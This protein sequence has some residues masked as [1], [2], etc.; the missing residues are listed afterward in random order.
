MI[1]SWFKSNSEMAILL[2]IIVL[3]GWVRRPTKWRKKRSRWLNAKIWS[4]WRLTHWIKN[5]IH[6]RKRSF[7]LSHFLNLLITKLF[8]KAQ[9]LKLKH[10][11]SKERVE[12]Q[13][14]LRRSNNNRRKISTQISE[15][16]TLKREHI[17]SL[18]MQLSQ[19]PKADSITWPRLLKF[20]ILAKT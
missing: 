9:S 6:L 10:L 4:M 3:Q 8:K 14:P 2:N 16:W 1:M 12:I 5:L 17:L 11:S 20:T 15:I 7:Q 13:E 18:N 19:R